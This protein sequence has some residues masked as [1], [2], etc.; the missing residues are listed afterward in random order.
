MSSSRAL[1]ARLFE[2]HHLAVFRYFL[3]MTGQR[4]LAQ[5]LTQDVFVRVVRAADSYADSGHELAWL[6][7]I[8]RNLLH[9]RHRRAG[10]QPP[11]VPLA[12]A[13]EVPAAESPG[14]ALEV[15]RAMSQLQET[16]REVFVLLDTV[17]LSYE[18]IANL[19]GLTVSAVR[20]RLHRA[21]RSLAA[22]LDLVRPRPA[23]AIVRR[24]RP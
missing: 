24:I 5:D 4:D 12:A 16:D 3:R 13:A 9:D 10:R 11:H 23:S 8:A 18:E 7:R 22:A 17:G 6:L 15:D 21:R 1:A 2:R 20:S 14:V 19:T